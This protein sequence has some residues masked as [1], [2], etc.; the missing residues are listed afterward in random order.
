MKDPIFCT[1]LW[2][3]NFYWLPVYLRVYVY[4]HS[5]SELQFST[6][7]QEKP[8][9]RSKLEDFLCSEKFTE[10]WLAADIYTCIRHHDISLVSE[11]REN[12]EDW[13]RQKR[14]C[15]P[16]RGHRE[17]DDGCLRRVRPW[18]KSH[19]SPFQKPLS[20]GREKKE[21]HKIHWFYSLLICI[22]KKLQTFSYIYKNVFHEKSSD[23]LCI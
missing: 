3:I 18:V 4:V 8:C 23:L 12:C 21:R 19:R 22:I 17:P 2:D 16:S 13:Q 15:S 20:W 5:E 11:T 6:C 10:P 1:D 14:D 9:F 7:N